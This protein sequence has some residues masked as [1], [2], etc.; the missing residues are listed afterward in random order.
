M[1]ALCHDI[2]HLPFSHAAESLLPDGWSHERLSREHILSPQMAPLW[3]ASEPQLTPAIIAKIA[4]GPAKAEQPFNVWEAILSEIV[5][6]DAFGVD[7]M[8]Y[9]LRDALHCGVAFGRFD[10]PRL[11]DTLR[12]LPQG[13]PDSEPALG[14]EWG[15]LQAAEGLSIARYFMYTSVYFHPVRQAYNLH[16]QQFFER[17]LDGGKFSTDLDDH[18]RLTDNE[19][20]TAIA[21]AARNPDAPGH[22]PARRIIERD[23]FK[24]AYDR[25]PDEAAVNPAAGLAIKAALETKYGPENVLHHTGGGGGGNVDFPVRLLDGS[26]ESSLAL[27]K[28][29]KNLPATRTDRVWITPELVEQ[30]R[31]WLNR[32]RRDQI[33][34]EA[35]PQEEA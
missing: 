10:H 33:I 20:L 17:W 6:G 22:D 7:R 2:G 11:I 1:G 13:G 16:L 27:S 23:H 28:T 14:V 29:L 21:D 18:V 24:L 34:G 12:I 25:T 30:A 5:V 19:V 8:D 35:A 31:T 9:L 32:E 15:G 26:V 3:A 4:V